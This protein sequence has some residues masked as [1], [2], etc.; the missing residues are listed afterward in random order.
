[1]EVAA[2][3]IADLAQTNRGGSGYVAASK[4]AYAAVAIVVGNSVVHLLEHGFVVTQGSCW[5]PAINLCSVRC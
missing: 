3:A 5:H 1:V 4:S 2:P